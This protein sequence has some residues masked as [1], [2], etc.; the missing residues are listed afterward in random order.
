MGKD[1]DQPVLQFFDAA[2]KVRASVPY[3]V[4]GDTLSVHAPALLKVI[5]RDTIRERFDTRWEPVLK[6]KKEW[7]R[8]ESK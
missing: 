8:V 5:V 6:D 1:K 3:E 2:G 4:K 7:R